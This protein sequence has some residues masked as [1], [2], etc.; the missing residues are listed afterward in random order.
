M[1][2]CF[3]WETF[4]SVQP[5]THCELLKVIATEAEKL[6]LDWTL[7]PSCPFFLA[8][9]KQCGGRGGALPQ[10]VH[11]N[12]NLCIATSIC[13]RAR[14]LH[15][16]KLKVDY[17]S[18]STTNIER[19]LKMESVMSSFRLVI[20]K[21]NGN[22]ELDILQLNLYMVTSIGARQPQSVQSN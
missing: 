3:F 5:R 1:D 14:E 15:L 16:Y 10:S 19:T 2:V 9:N 18:D 20:N 8:K 13:A 4:D 21:N 22:V 6:L 17:I 12:L 7:P 11:G